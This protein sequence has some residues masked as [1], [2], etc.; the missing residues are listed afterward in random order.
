MYELPKVVKSLEFQR[1]QQ[2]SSFRTWQKK[3][4]WN[5]KVPLIII[6]GTFFKNVW[7]YFTENKIP[8]LPFF[9]YAI[10]IP[11]LFTF[12]LSPSPLHPHYIPTTSSFPLPPPLLFTST[13][14]YYPTLR[15]TLSISDFH[16]PAHFQSLHI[17][18]HNT[19]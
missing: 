4:P 6:M 5:Q 3:C 18:I 17:N 19:I 1:L 14:T 11:I 10:T 13:F 15:S 12:V 2:V 7:G 16:I 9:A 8:F